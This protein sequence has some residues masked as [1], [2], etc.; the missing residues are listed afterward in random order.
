MGSLERD[1]KTKISLASLCMVSTVRLPQG[2][3]ASDPAAPRAPAGAPAAAPRPAARHTALRGRGRGACRQHPLRPSSP[4]QRRAGSTR[5]T[6]HSP[7]GPMAAT[8]TAGRL[9]APHRTRYRPAGQRRAFV[10]T[11]ESWA[12]APSPCLRPF[13]PGLPAALA[14]RSGRLRTAA[15]QAREVPRGGDQG[16]A[17][18]PRRPPRPGGRRIAP[19]ADSQ[20]APAAVVTRW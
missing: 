17:A 14:P 19:A 12:T 9:S 11:H 1:A 6:E 3:P 4:A 2:P 20:A 5:P 10:S 16:Q 8:V 15:G 13:G 18:V 7:A